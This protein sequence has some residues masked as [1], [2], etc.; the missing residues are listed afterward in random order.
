MVARRFPNGIRDSVRAGMRASSK[1]PTEQRPIRYQ[2][3]GLA[4]AREAANMSVEEV[5]E[6]CGYSP[7][8]ITAMESG[9]AFHT[10]SIS[11]VASVIPNHDLSLIR[12]EG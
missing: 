1:L 12:D 9:V 11:R 3:P 7:G 5:A 8:V 2:A 10:V 4:A 6:L